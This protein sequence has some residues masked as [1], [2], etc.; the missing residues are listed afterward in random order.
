MF[1]PSSFAID[2]ETGV[3]NSIQ[4]VF[5]NNSVW[6]CY[7]HLFQNMKKHVNKANLLN[8]YNTD[9]D[10]AV[11]CKMII[12]LA[13]VNPPDLKDAFHLLCEVFENEDEINPLIEWFE[14]YYIGAE[15]RRGNR[16]VQLEP[17]FPP[18]MWSVY[19]RTL[20]GAS[21]T[22]NYA[23]AAN[24]RIQSE[25]GVCHPT[26]GNFILSLKK[27]QH[28]RDQQYMQWV[29]GLEPPHNAPQGTG[30]NR[31]YWEVPNL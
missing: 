8:R 16:I 6:F 10:F 20:D 19:Q 27:V 28:G 13:F 4:A 7:F 25:L 17:R 9:P 2:F 5:P 3:M 1:N 22:N 26:L 14:K 23:E 11:K 12:A 21:R 29:A 18:E 24:R 31:R 15:R 30:Q